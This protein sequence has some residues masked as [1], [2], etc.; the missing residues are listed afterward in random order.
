MR[1][2]HP[3]ISRPPFT[4]IVRPAM[5]HGIAANGQPGA[6]GFGGVTGYADNAAHLIV[7]LMKLHLNRQNRGVDKKF[8]SQ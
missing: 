6:L 7:L 5:S 2:A 1:Q 8:F 4:S 3:P